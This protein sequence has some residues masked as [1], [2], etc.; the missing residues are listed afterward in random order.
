MFNDIKGAIFDL[1]GT[2]IDS[3]WVW[4][5]IDYDY[6]GK[7]GI[8]LPI[9]L[10]DHITHLS[11]ND[12]AKYFKERFRLKESLEE[13]K[14]EWNAMALY[15]Y[16]H[17]IILK[18]GVINFLH[19]LKAKD[20]KIALA[21]SNS[22][23]LLELALKRNGVYQYFDVITTT[24]EVSRNKSFPDVY[25]LAADRL[26]VNADSCVVFEDILPAIIGAKAAGM[27]VVGVHDSSSEHQRNDIC[28][29]ADIFINDYQELINAV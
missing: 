9:D 12:T 16:S 20:I 2:L 1:D 23:L 22:R 8:D 15:E 25:L 13:I 17:N 7:R 14:I 21:T 5:K 18:P 11:F 10:K 27:K 19:F 26:G 24:D 6:L 4:S 29:I 3:M 28:K